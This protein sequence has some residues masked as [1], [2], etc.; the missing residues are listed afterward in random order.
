MIL[1]S[2]NRLEEAKSEAL[3]TTDILD[4]LGAV[5]DVERCKEHLRVIEKKLNTP[6]ISGQSGFNYEFLKI[7]L[8]PACIE[9][10]L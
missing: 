7:F 9:S 4:R 2:Q 1:Y 3:R 6:V 8:F 10:S 5:G